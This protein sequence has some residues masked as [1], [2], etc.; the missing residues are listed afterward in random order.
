[1]SPGDAMTPQTARRGPAPAQADSR[2]NRA[3]FE[4]IGRSLKWWYWFAAGCALGLALAGWPHGLPL[5]MATV[6]VQIGH[7]LLRE[8]RIAAF[9]VQVPTLF[10]AV[11]ALGTWE[12]LG[13]IHWVQLVGTWVRLVF[14]YCLAA[15]VMSL[16]PWNR[17]VGLSWPLVR[18]TFLAPPARGSFVAAAAQG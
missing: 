8:R 18:R 12:P 10:L 6:G 7:F 9:P 3:S 2:S 16:A 13:F 1:M 17:R 4:H 15:R 5:A 14:D 11:L